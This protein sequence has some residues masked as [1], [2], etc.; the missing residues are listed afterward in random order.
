MSTKGK[1]GNKKTSKVN[2]RKKKPKQ[3]PKTAKKAIT[4]NTRQKKP[5]PQPKTAK[6][7]SQQRQED[8]FLYVP[9]IGIYYSSRRANL[10]YA[11]LRDGDFKHAKGMCCVCNRYSYNKRKYTYN[12]LYIQRW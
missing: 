7:A 8:W 11:Q 5:K 6:K 1:T 9:F 3:P 10:T 12:T 4:T 2:T